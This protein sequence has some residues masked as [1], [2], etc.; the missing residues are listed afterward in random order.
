[1]T[2]T[3]L[4]QLRTFSLTEDMDALRIKAADALESAEREIE[5]LQGESEKKSVLINNLTERLKGPDPHYDMA[6]EIE[7]LRAEIGRLSGVAE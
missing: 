7:N 2:R 3:I 4:E 5:R 1:M 6:R